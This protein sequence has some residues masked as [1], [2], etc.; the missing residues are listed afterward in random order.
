MLPLTSFFCDVLPTKKDDPQYYKA[1]LSQYTLISVPVLLS[2]GALIPSGL[3]GD[4]DE[5]DGMIDQTIEEIP[6]NAN[7][8]RQRFA[9]YTGRAL[10][11]QPEMIQCSEDRTFV[12][13]LFIEKAKAY[14]ISN[15]ELALSGL[16]ASAFISYFALLEDTLQRIHFEIFGKQERTDK[17][18]SWGL[19]SVCLSEI[20]SHKKIT[21]KFT[22]ELATRSEF[23]LNI[24]ILSSVWELLNFIRNRLIHSG[25]KLSFNAQKIWHE[26]LEGIIGAFKD[27]NVPE[28]T[29]SFIHHLE[30]IESDFKSSGYLR[31]NNALENCIRNTCVSIMESLV[32]CDR[33]IKQQNHTKQI[34]Q[35]KY[36]KKPQRSTRRKKQ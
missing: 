4:K 23:Y 31:L 15:R 2:Q 13:E 19:I 7:L 33:A 34:T 30:L 26:K 14:N 35:S 16:N 6:V 3:E 21:E 24:E 29:L 36:F 10:S 28:V 25:G 22:Q 11:D 18:T 32:V 17:I 20:L 8:K 27:F 1:F 5:L 12:S 9:V